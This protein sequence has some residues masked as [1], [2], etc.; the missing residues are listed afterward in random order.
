MGFWRRVAA[1]L[2]RERWTPW[3]VVVH[4]AWATVL[5]VGGA[6]H[7]FV[8]WVKYTWARPA[9]FIAG[10]VEVATVVIAVRALRRSKG[11]DRG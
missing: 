1:R 3:R 6:T 9:W 10:G 4:T 7:V 5:L 2:E 11:G 8:P